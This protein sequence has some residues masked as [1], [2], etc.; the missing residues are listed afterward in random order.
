[1]KEQRS[2]S[3]GCRRVFKFSE[4]ASKAPLKEPP[5]KNIMASAEGTAAATPLCGFVAGL[6]RVP[7][8]KRQLGLVGDHAIGIHKTGN[9]GCSGG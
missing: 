4:W 6:G 5:T 9:H 8:H 3:V 1:M 7:A 2:L